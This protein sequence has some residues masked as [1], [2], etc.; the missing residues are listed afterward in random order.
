MNGKSSNFYLQQGLDS[1]LE[2]V[3][4]AEFITPDW[5]QLDLCFPFYV[6]QYKPVEL[7]YMCEQGPIHCMIATVSSRVQGF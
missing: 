7:H 3:L 5:K 6:H 1:I 2:H 4:W